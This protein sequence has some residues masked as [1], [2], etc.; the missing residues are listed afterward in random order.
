MFA[1]Q[2]KSIL[3]FVLGKLQETG[4]IYLYHN[5]DSGAKEI[6]FRLSSAV[7]NLNFADS[8]MADE[9]VKIIAAMDIDRNGHRLTSKQV[10]ICVLD[11]FHL[12]VCQ[13]TLPNIIAIHKEVAL[14]RYLFS[15]KYHISGKLEVVSESGPKWQLGYVECDVKL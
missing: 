6:I 9:S 8:S 13:K 4:N 5:K 15:G 12:E 14:P 10:D 11:I 3:I 2:A 7:E 1:F